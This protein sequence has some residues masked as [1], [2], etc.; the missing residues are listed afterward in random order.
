MPNLSFDFYEIKAPLSLKL[1]RD[2]YSQEI[3]TGFLTIDGSKDSSKIHA[4]K[5]FDERACQNVVGV[6]VSNI[7]EETLRHP[8]L[9]SACARLVLCEA[10][11]KAKINSPSQDKNTFMVAV[12]TT[13]DPQGSA[14]IFEFKIVQNSIK[15]GA[16]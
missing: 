16:P 1:D 4:N 8:V 13:D 15:R 11:L 3:E 2:D 10:L 5:T 9:W 7:S 12:F 14:K 6:W